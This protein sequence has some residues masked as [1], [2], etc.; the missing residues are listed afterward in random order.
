MPKKSN[1]IFRFLNSYT[2]VWICCRESY[3]NTNQL[4]LFH[5]GTCGKAVGT[6]KK[7]THISED[8][9]YKITE[10]GKLDLTET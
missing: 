2:Q 8:T 6:I 4:Y 7:I 10:L 1:K 3:T 5:L 9:D